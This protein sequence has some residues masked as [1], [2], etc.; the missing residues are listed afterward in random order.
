[1]SMGQILQ[2]GMV[3]GTVPK[4]PVWEGEI[5]VDTPPPPLHPVYYNHR[6]SDNR[7]SKVFK[8]MDLKVKYS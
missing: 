5:V 3:T 1:M 8:N 4:F 7:L 6:V 2:F